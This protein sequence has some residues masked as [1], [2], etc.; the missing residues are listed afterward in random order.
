LG[1]LEERLLPLFPRFDAQ[2]DEFEQ[3]AIIAQALAFGQ[4]IYL[5]VVG[6]YDS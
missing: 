5:L 3:N 6:L 2:F 4:T 1:Q